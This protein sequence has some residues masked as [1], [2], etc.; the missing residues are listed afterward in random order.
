[1][2]TIMNVQTN[3]RSI[4]PMII[5]ATTF[6]PTFC[7]F[8][9]LIYIPSPASINSLVILIALGPSRFGS[10]RGRGLFLEITAVTNDQRQRES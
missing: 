2:S 1:M 7:L 6:V 9:L 10:R 8:V 3:V 4:A 5:Q